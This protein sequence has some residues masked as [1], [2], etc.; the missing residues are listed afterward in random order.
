M[1][2]RA[3]LFDLDETIW[4]TSARP[5]WE[6]ITQ[7]Q[8][9]ELAPY[10]RSLH[11]DELDVTAFIRRFWSRFDELISIDG[12]NLEEPRWREGPGLMRAALIENGVACTALDGQRLWEACHDVSLRHFNVALF[13]DT[14]SAL[15]ALVF[16]GQRLGVVTARPLPR[17]IIAR[18]LRG[19]G[20]SYVFDPIVTS[21]DVGYRKPHSLLFE[22]ALNRLGLQPDEIVVV[23]DSYEEDV[24]PAA[25]LGMIPVLKLNGRL[26]D[27][28]L[29][30]ARYQVPSL[31]AL[32]ELEIL[33][34]VGLI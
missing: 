16:R 32:T 4:T 29:G 3:V 1:A 26:P 21:G 8:A 14:A 30:L 6:K 24:V 18:E 7:L 31:A 11:P 19:Q 5:D 25:N 27:E 2:I 33:Q 10:L 23:G 13:P 20:I 34:P 28:N 12:E 9:A 17:K 15:A 22:S